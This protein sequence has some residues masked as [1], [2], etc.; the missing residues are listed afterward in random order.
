MRYLIVLDFEATCWDALVR[1]KDHEIIEFPSVVVD[2]ETGKIVDTLEQFVKPTCDPTVSEFCHNLTTITQ[3]QVDGGISFAEAFKA[4]QLF[5]DKYRD[6]IIVTCGDWDLKTMLPMDCKLNGI[7]LP[8]Y[9]KR[10]INLKRPF[11]KRYN[12]KV[13]GFNSML[14]DKN[15][16][17]TFDGTPHRGIDDCRNIAR[18]A[19]KMLEQGWVPVPTTGKMPAH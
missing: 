2:T 10:W 14:E 13:R 11:E 7:E 3:E 6:S 9:Y 12:V 15:I 17:L 18:V 8:G 5:V 4:H 16:G 19:I 1:Y